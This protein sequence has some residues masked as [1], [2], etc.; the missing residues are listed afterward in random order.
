[1]INFSRTI[2]N[3]LINNNYYFII[4]ADYELFDVENRI[5]SFFSTFTLIPIFL[6]SKLN[7][8]R[9]KLKFLEYSTRTHPIK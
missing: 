6:D 8:G 7:S 1:M 4:R 2:P 3:F 9:H 5:V